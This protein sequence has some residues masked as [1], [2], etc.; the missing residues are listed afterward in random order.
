MFG[1]LVYAGYRLMVLA[2]D[3]QRKLLALGITSMIGQLDSGE[4]GI[5]H[6]GIKSKSIFVVTRVRQGNPA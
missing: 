5:G 4:A 6:F 3:P 2:P 1:C